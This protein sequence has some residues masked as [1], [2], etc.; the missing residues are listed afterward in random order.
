MSTLFATFFGPITNTL[1]D[2]TQV[3]FF[4]DISFC[5]SMYG[6][7]FLAVKETFHTNKNYP[8][9]FVKFY[10]KIL[11]FRFL[12]ESRKLILSSHF[13]QLVISYTKGVH[14][15]YISV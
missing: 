8:F 7:K 2:L 11:F 12:L 5:S 3:Y 6:L 15:D 4:G 9:P 14:G 1:F 10:N 13:N